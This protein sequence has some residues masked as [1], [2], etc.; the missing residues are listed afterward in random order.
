MA[1]TPE[2]QLAAEVRGKNILVNAAAGSGKTKVLTERI[3]GIISDKDNPVDI[4]ELLIVTFTKAAAREMRER[5]SGSLTER[6]LKNPG[7]KHLKRQ[8]IL[9]NSADITTIDAFCLDVVKSNFH[10]LELDPSFSV[11]GEGEKDIILDEIM[12][13]VFEESYAADNPAFLDTAERYSEKNSD[14]PLR[15]IVKKIYKHLSDAQNINGEIEKLRRFYSEPFE[16][17]SYKEMIR[18]EMPDIINEICKSYMISSDIL[19]KYPEDNISA[20]KTTPVIQSELN[21]WINIKQKIENGEWDNAVKLYESF[22]LEHFKLGRADWKNIDPDHAAQIKKIR[23]M[24]DKLKLDAYFTYT[25]EL[26]KEKINGCY[27]D[28]VNVFLDLAKAVSDKY[29]AKKLS[30]NKFEFSDIERMCLELLYDADGE[31]SDICLRLLDKYH[32]ILIDEYQDSNQLQEDIFSSIS[33]GHNMF[34]VGDMKQSIYAF[35]GSEPELFKSKCSF[36]TDP[37]ADSDSLKVVLSKNFRS[38]DAVIS[39]VNELFTGIMSEENGDIDYDDEQRLYLGNTNYDETQN[40]GKLL[41]AELD[42]I[43]MSGESAAGPE[44]PSAA[45]DDDGEDLDKIRT[46]ARFAAKRILELKKSGYMTLDKNTNKYRPLENRDIAVLMRSGKE[47]AAVYAEELNRL[48]ISAYAQSSG[49]FN[50]PEV[51]VI[52]SLLKVINNPLCDIPFI[53]VM[54]SVIYGIS[55]D[56]LAHIHIYNRNNHIYENMLAMLNAGDDDDGLRRLSEDIEYFRSCAKFMPCDKLIW[57]IYERTGFYNICAAMPDGEGK[58]ANLILLFERA[59]IFENSGFKGLFNFIRLITC[60]IEKANDRTGSSNNMNEAVLISESHNVVNVM[61]IHKSKGLEFPVVI[62]SQAAKE[63]NNEYLKKPIIIDKKMGIGINYYEP[64]KYYRYPTIIRR[65]L[66]KR[67]RRADL[68]ENMRVLY[69]ALT[70]AR[71]KLIVISTQNSAPDLTGTEY[72]DAGDAKSFYDWILPIA[73]KSEKYWDVNII[74]KADAV[75]IAPEEEDIPP[76]G[77]EMPDISDIFS[78]GYKYRNA[79]GLEAKI[80]VTELKRRT[81]VEEDS[82]NMYSRDIIVQKPAFL[83]DSRITPAQRGTVIHALMQNI[84]LKTDIDEEYLDGEIIRLTECGIFTEKEAECIDKDK[85]LRFFASDIGRRMTASDKVYREM[86]FEIPISASEADAGILNES[87]LLQGIID[88]YFEEPDG[89]VLI[90]YKTDY[91][92]DKDE[93]RK[94]YEAQI[95]YYKRAIEI[96]T[97]KNVKDTYLYLFFNNDV[98]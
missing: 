27:K 50:K 33:N 46:E 5:I 13:E 56:K 66:N 87:I 4:D 80:S 35:R 81:L 34:M 52:L 29:M 21:E 90:D 25:G 61:T 57:T 60:L 49:Y 65:I 96:L 28:T 47:A 7:D 42:I 15:D 54:C 17:G 38:N 93:I 69:V 12:E 97:K 71:E 53:A 43:D 82:R 45:G 8:L 94:K 78:A 73:A 58:C 85:I 67:R 30:I 36:P 22:K 39:A 89:L 62:L 91:Y 68:S 3:I 32:E 55:E 20:I 48:G 59:R 9:L 70:R 44:K 83:R 37:A 24:P 86:R 11:I 26:L 31:K 18:K 72:K 77:T 88:C 84:I 14:K 41:R 51:R 19:S 2:Q 92:T 76:D 79:T 74:P 63:F 6:V 95:G 75:N 1:M 23:D 98:V 40:P 16:N 64:E 10:R